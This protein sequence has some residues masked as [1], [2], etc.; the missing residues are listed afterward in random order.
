[1]KR[2]LLHKSLFYIL[3]AVMLSAAVS[4]CNDEPLADLP[5]VNDGAIRIGAGVGKV[6]ATRDYITEGYGPVTSGTFTL[7][8]P[9]YSGWVNS[10]LGTLYYLCQL[11]EVTFGYAGQEDIGFVNAANPSTDAPKDLV[12]SRLNNSSNDG[13]YIYSN[14]PGATL[15]LDNVPKPVNS[16]ASDSIVDFTNAKYADC[17][18]RFIAN[19]YAEDGSND[20]LWG[21]SYVA[22]NSQFINFNLIHCLSRLRLN[23]VVDKSES[24]DN[25][26]DLSLDNA[27][28][29]IND[30]M[31]KPYKF[32]RHHGTI[33]FNSADNPQNFWLVGNDPSST[34]PN[35]E[36]GFKSSW[37]SK[38]I[39]ESE[40]TITYQTFDFVIPPQSLNTGQNRQKLIIRLPASDYNSAL[41]YEP[42]DS[43]TFWAYIPSSMYLQTDGGSASMSLNLLRGYDITLTTTMRPG[44][45]E[46]EFMPVTVEEWVNKGDF[47]PKADQ[48]GIPNAATFYEMMEYYKNY[49]AFQLTRY[50]FLN[51]NG[52]WDFQFRGE[53]I[54]LE[55]TRV[56]GQMMRS[57]EKPDFIPDFRNRNELLILPDGSEYGLMRLGN[58]GQGQLYTILTTEPNTGI[59]DSS[60]FTVGYKNETQYNGTT[61]LLGLISAYQQNSW[62]LGIYGDYDKDSNPSKPWTFKISED[63]TLDYDDIATQMLVR[64]GADFSFNFDGHTVTIENAPP[65]INSDLT[66]TTGEQ[67]LYEIVS[68]RLSGLYS[69]QDFMNMVAAYNQSYTRAEGDLEYYGTNSGNAWIFPVWRNNITVNRRNIQGMMPMMENATYSFNFRNNTVIVVEPDQVNTQ[70]SKEAGMQKLVD[71]LSGPKLTGVNSSLALQQMAEEFISNPATTN[72]NLTQFGYVNSGTWLFEITTDITLQYDDIVGIMSGTSSSFILQILEDYFVTIQ[73][74]DDIDPV[75][76]MGDEGAAELYSILTMQPEMPEPAPE[77]TPDADPDSDMEPSPF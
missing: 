71:I 72:I 39:N 53:N 9:Y 54:A 52:V 61:T 4:S 28:V 27:S 75:I 16:A 57:P 66:G 33:T 55:Q 46:L 59:K 5:P 73:Y 17:A 77:P 37:K 24:S 47:N 74:G 69:A 2:L 65:G 42:N 60:W 6:N 14:Q 11:A 45:P 7:S 10:G 21:E 49:N 3:P 19:Q 58:E 8:Y 25:S 36:Q 32:D 51:S 44:E 76:L 13:I 38:T 43:V 35:D 56:A 12:W 34:V 1:M 62:E 18:T 64:E 41:G 68:T 30:L 22:K 67:T 40:D 20:L 23:V 15:Y 29:R 63:I 70:L 31:L 26:F 48:N 50:G